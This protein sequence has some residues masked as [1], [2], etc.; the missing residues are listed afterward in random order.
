MLVL[1][2]ISLTKTTVCGMTTPSIFQNFPTTGWKW[3]QPSLPTYWRETE[4]RTLMWTESWRWMWW[5][6]GW[7]VYICIQTDLSFH[8]QLGASSLREGCNISVMRW[9]VRRRS[10]FRWESPYKETITNQSDLDV[11]PHTSQS[12]N[13][14]KVSWLW[15]VKVCYGDIHSCRFTPIDNSKYCEDDR[16]THV[17]TS[18]T[19]GFDTNFCFKRLLKSGE[20]KSSVFG[21]MKWESYLLKIMSF[22]VFPQ[23]C[24]Q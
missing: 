4:P 15:N 20:S 7:R 22:N 23:A 18:L 3:R 12:W 10:M 24:Y 19:Y 8:C 17:I 13:N 2:I 5:V 21:E 16:Y 6:G 9:R 11:V 14:S 1:G